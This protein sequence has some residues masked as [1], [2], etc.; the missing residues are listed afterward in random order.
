MQHAE[1]FLLGII[2][3]LTEFIPV[4]STAHLRLLSAFIQHKDPGA[5]FSAVIQL[6]T[7]I[8]LVV[9]FRKDLWNLFTSSMKAISRGEFLSD[10]DSRLVW[11]LILGTIPVSVCGLLFSRFITGNARSLY[12]IAG[13]LIIMA[14]FLWLADRNGKKVRSIENAT[15]KDFLW[16]GM[17]QALAL[18]PG[19]SRS[20]T[21]LTIGLFIGFTRT[22]AMRISFLLSIPAIALSGLYEAFMERKALMEIGTSAIIIGI[23]VSSL[24]GYFAIRFML[25]YLTNH[26]TL[27][28]VIY[29]VGL[30]VTLLILLYFNIL[31]PFG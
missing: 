25:R 20:G 7:L 11:Y 8:S 18:I 13:S 2:Q 22:A 26:T 19:A 27:L 21:T 16:I 15:W 24:I 31:R 28:F 9:Y 10:T 6:G 23:G 30:G 4:S 1:A 29:R 14:L 12:V 5:A 3:G 17:A